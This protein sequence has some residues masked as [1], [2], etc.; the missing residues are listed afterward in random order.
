MS[1]QFILRLFEFI[2]LFVRANR[3]ESTA[4]IQASLFV[5]QRFKVTD[6]KPILKKNARKISL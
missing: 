4:E 1:N 6:N 3:F 5:C 2:K